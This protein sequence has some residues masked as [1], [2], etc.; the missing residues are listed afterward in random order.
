MHRIRAAIFTVLAAAV[1]A[2]AAAQDQY[3]WS[4]RVPAGQTI[5]IKG[6]NGTIRAV[7]ATGSDVR[8]SATRSARRSDPSE[9]TFEVVPHSGG[10]TICAMYPSRPG[11][12]PNQC[13]PGSAGRMNVQ[14]NDVNV[15][16]LVQVPAGVN[17]T[18]RNVNGGIEATGLPAHV[19]AV[20]V[21]GGI[22]V[23]TSGTAR[24]TTVN[25]AINAAVGRADWTGALEFETVNGTI[26]VSLPGNVSADVSATTVNGDIDTDF[27]LTV[28][29]RFGPRRVS[30]TIGSGGR[31]LTLRTV[32]GAIAIRRN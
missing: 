19:E 24:A 27:P 3:A 25:G 18:G 5:E 32:N 13:R 17:F 9:V 14:N 20:T 4:G 12:E 7:A 21:N 29:G 16:W 15:E 22:T 30:G 6:I 28:S 26:S 31:Q 1:A 23:S 2:P 8:V 11:R 10:V